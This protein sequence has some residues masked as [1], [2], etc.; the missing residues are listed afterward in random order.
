MAA[1]LAAIADFSRYSKPPPLGGG[2]FTSEALEDMAGLTEVQYAGAAALARWA[3]DNGER[4]VP[5][6]GVDEAHSPVGVG[7]HALSRCVAA[8]HWLPAHALID[9]PLV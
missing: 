3:A 4:M 5:Q 6:S 8:L 7:R 9:K 2:V 1:A